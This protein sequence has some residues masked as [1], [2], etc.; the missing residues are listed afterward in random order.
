MISRN[1]SHQDPEDGMI[2]SLRARSGEVLPK[3]RSFGAGQGEG[4]FACL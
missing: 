2:N 4:G 1:K 3:G